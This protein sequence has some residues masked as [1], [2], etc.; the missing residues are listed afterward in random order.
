MIARIVEPTSKADSRRV[1]ADVGATVMSYKTIQ[2]HLAMI[3][4]GG[5]RDAIAGKMLRPLG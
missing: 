5:Y 4:P 1:L 2:R 3:G